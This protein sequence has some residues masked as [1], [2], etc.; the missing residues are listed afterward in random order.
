[1]NG[2]TDISAG[3]SIRRSGLLVAP[4]IPKARTH[5]RYAIVILLALLSGPLVRPAHAGCDANGVWLQ[6]LGSGGPEILQD[7]RAS[8]SYLVW[9]NGKARLLVDAG[10]GSALNFGK[11]GASFRDLDAIVFSH[12]HVDHSTDLPVLVKASYFGERAR[13]LP[14][15]GP[16]GNWLMPSMQGFIQAMFAGKRGAFRYLSDFVDASE[17]SAYKLIANDVPAAGKSTWSGF[18]NERLQ[19]SA[20]PVHHGPVPALAWRV[21][22]AGHSITFSGD[23]NG[24]NRTLEKLARD[25]DILVAHNAIPEI[26]TGV[27]RK[28][29]MPPS[30]I[31][32]IASES[33]VKQLV[34]SHRMRRTLGR[35]V[36]T[37]RII[38][39]SYT[40]PV[41]FSDD[42]DCFQP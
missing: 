19:L 24:D 32:K 17:P 42:L 29:H 37:Q 23:M 20:I 10:G 4:A 7:S 27:A 11:S 14:L 15:F 26:A 34:L 12:F 6:V 39:Q 3:Y 18:H 36:Q 41:A 30:V 35:E 31:G 1:M 2:A 22:I 28:L 25:S 9:L 16:T 13:D 21:D 38:Q 33:R 5:R 8:S 40:G